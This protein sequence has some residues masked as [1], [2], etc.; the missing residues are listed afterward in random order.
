MARKHTLPSLAQTSWYWQSCVPRCQAQSDSLAATLRWCT[1]NWAAHTA[2]GTRSGPISCQ[3]IYA[4]PQQA[5]FRHVECCANRDWLSLNRR[6]QRW[7]CSSRR[8]AANAKRRTARHGSSQTIQFVARCTL[9]NRAWKGAS[10]HQLLARRPSNTLLQ[11]LLS[12]PLRCERSKQS[13][14][15]AIPSCCKLLRTRAHNR[16]RRVRRDIWTHFKRSVLRHTFVHAFDQSAFNRNRTATIEQSALTMRP[17]VL[18]RAHRA[19]DRAHGYATAQA[20]ASSS[21][22][23]G[24]G[25][26]TAHGGG[27]LC[28]VACA[29]NGVYALNLAR[30]FDVSAAV[31]RRLGGYALQTAPRSW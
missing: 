4:G 3:Q 27:T 17:A 18:L 7:I 23:G 9:P 1:C 25:P 15:R 14:C 31:A 24:L 12:R 16:V 26:T 8:T 19:H 2:P 10:E 28:T 5:D 22:H 30:G 20:Q 21:S 11:G 29:V 6:V 13:L